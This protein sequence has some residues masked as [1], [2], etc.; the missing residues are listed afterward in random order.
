MSSNFDPE[1]ARVGSGPAC[2]IDPSRKNLMRFE[3]VM[4]VLAAGWALDTHA[5]PVTTVDWGLH[6]PFETAS[7]QPKGNT[8][9]FIVF[10]VKADTALFSTAVSNHT[11]GALGRK[12][13]TVYLF[14]GNSDVLVGSYDFSAETGSIAHEFALHAGDYQYRVVGTGAGASGGAYT[15]SSSLTG[16]GSASMV[17]AALLAEARAVPEPQSQWLVLAGLAAVGWVSRRRES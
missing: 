11:D 2:D 17:Q 16:A 10:E 1:D 6:D 9:D 14:Q 15:L 7:I 4:I 8:D 5:T 12:G 3:L 13:G